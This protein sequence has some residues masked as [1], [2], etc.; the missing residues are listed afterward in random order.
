MRLASR[1]PHAMWRELGGHAD[2]DI[3]FRVVQGFATIGRHQFGEVD[4]DEREGGG[5]AL[6]LGHLVELFD[7]ICQLLGEL[8]NMGHRL[9]H[10]SRLH[11]FIFLLKNLVAIV[12]DGVEWRT[13]GAADVFNEN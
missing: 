7:V 13:E 8:S 3:G 11:L 2:A 4:L 9:P 5:D 12:V 10:L 1:T 6:E